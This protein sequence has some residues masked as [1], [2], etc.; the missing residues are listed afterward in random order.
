MVEAESRIVAIVASF[1]AF[2]PYASRRGLILG[3]I[4]VS[5]QSITKRKRPKYIRINFN[6]D[7][8]LSDRVLLLIKEF[9]ARVGFV[10]RMILLPY[11]YIIPML[12]A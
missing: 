12:T 1:V 4:I 6:G 9:S 3:K 7:A 10:S 11:G 8:L 2:T 5:N